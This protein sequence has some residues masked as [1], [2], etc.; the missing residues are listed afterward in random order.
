MNPQ[1]R[2]LRSVASDVVS[3]ELDANGKAGFAWIRLPLGQ[4]LDSIQYTYILRLQ[5]LILPL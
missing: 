4:H 2:M 3:V 1:V 5:P